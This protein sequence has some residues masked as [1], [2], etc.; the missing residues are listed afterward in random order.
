[1]NPLFP[2]YSEIQLPLLAEIKRRDGQTKPSD[3]NLEGKSVY[4]A[5]ADYFDL[6]E[7]ARGVTIDDNGTPR[8]KWNN[9]VRWTRNDLKKAGLLYAPNHGVWAL[10][11]RG[12]EV[13]E[14][15]QLDERGAKI[16]EVDY[17]ISPEAFKTL[18]EKASNIGEEG[19]LFVL[20]YE[21]QRLKKLGFQNLA[22]QVVQISKLN[23][24]AG[25]DILSY[26]QNGQEIFIEVKTSIGSH[27]SFEITENELNKARQFQDSYFVYKVIN[28]ANLPKIVPI[29]NPAR[30]VD[31]GKLILK[32]TQWKAI[33]SEIMD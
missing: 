21:K 22:D 17:E 33:P 13:L 24:A 4:L 29:C 23:V 2:K 1:M 14:E 30:L 6:S 19:E 32:P 15:S 11:T 10:T 12:F 20:D 16:V 26:D 3:L 5:L 28:F 31:E 25:Y 7:E 18:M 8:S 27:L 9:M